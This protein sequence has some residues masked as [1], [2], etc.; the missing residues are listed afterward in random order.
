[1][2]EENKPTL[3]ILRMVDG[4]T[5]WAATVTGGRLLR[6]TDGGTNWSDVTPLNSS[7]QKIRVWN[8]TALSSLI[9]WVMP[10]SDTSPTEIFR[11][12][13]GGSTWRRAV[14]PPPAGVTRI[15]ASSISFINPR[16]G[17]LLASLA[18][19]A[20]SEAVEIY[21]STDG[22]ERWNG[23]G[24][25]SGLPFGGDKSAIAFLSSSTGWLT[26]AILR[27]DTP[28]LYVTHDSG[29]TWGEQNMPLPPEVTPHWNGWPQPPK[30]FTARDGVL[31]IFY[32]LYAGPNDDLRGTGMM[33]VAIYATHDGGTTWPF[34]LVKSV[35]VSVCLISFADMNHGWVMTGNDL[36]VTSDGGRRWTTMPPNPLLTDVGLLDFISPQVGWAWR[37]PSLYK[38]LDGGRT[39]TPVN[40]TILR[41]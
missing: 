31:P 19:A 35:N 20:G 13:D 18:A 2:Q 7:G 29:R 36:H 1:M 40:Y 11:T 4:Q 27:K 26:G 9:A 25:V 30:F 5:G 15:S 24:P 34:A 16:E 23:V 10:S 21:R 38:T 17:W 39:W 14:P 6:T 32:Y 41:K 28:Y 8:I 22:G 33:V 37:S 3:K 12:L